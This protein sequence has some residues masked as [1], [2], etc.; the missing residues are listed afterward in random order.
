M[1]DTRPTP[2]SFPA[3]LRLCLLLLVSPKRFT[4]EEKADQIARSNYR[5]SSPQLER[6]VVVRSAFFKS[7]CLVVAFSAV[8]YLAGKVMGMLGRCATPEAISLAQV[9][10][11]A[12][13]LWGTLFVRGW[14]I[15]SF[16]GVQLSERVNQWLYRG[17]YCIGTAVVVYSLS[18]AQCKG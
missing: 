9:I 10:G 16:S 2:L 12:V 13:L 17:L 11:A 4:E 6:A 18:F 5:D 8:G 1:A 3:A 14:E 7:F 15:Q